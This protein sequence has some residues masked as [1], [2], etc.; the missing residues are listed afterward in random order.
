M[1]DSPAPSPSSPR[2]IT[3]PNILFAII[4]FAG[5]F[6]RVWEF[7]ALPAGLNQ[8]EASIGLDAYDLLHY[9]VDRNNVSFPVNF[10]SWDSGMDA[11]YGYI[12]IPFVGFGLTAFTIRLP[13]LLSGILS[14][15]LIYFVGKRTL[16]VYFGLI[17]MF[18]LAISPWHIMMSR[19]GLNDNILPFVFLA[20]FAA[21]VNSTLENKW[22]LVASFFF[23][24]CLYAYGAA[25]VAVPLFLL[26]AIPIL[27]IHKSVS[28]RTAIQ[29]VCIFVLLSAPIG[30]FLLVNSLHLQS[31]AIG[32]Y[33]IPRL[34]TQARYE[35][36]AAIFS[37]DPLSI[38]KNN[39]IAAIQ[40][41]MGKSDGLPWNELTNYQYFYARA[42]ILSFVGAVLLIPSWGMRSQKEKWLMLSW[43]A[44]A[45]CIGLMQPVNVNRFNLI[46]IPLIF[47]AAVCVFC[48][49]A[50][51][52]P[53]S[54]ILLVP[55][56]A[57]FILFNRDYHGIEYRQSIGKE[58]F[59]GLL[60]ALE[61]TRSM[62][63]HPVCVTGSVN[64]PYIYVLFLEKKNPADYIDHLIYNQPDSSFRTVLFYGR[65]SFGDPLC[66]R[67]PDAV[68]ILSSG[69]S[70]DT[71]SAYESKTFGNFIVYYPKQP[72]DP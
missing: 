11:L 51:A 71:A 45:F 18:F 66:L 50:Y 22:F 34:P 15:P 43:L 65:Y 16:G 53:F 28:L 26:C 72:G 7:A 62:D 2:W 9:G 14:L 46:F 6:A 70:M 5:I 23:G 48:L 37:A 4:L 32:P 64:Q 30:L 49:L 13:L 60:P 42:Y 27:L 67:Q 59:D 1:N 40:L 41:I 52:R 47:C 68:S 44:A 12:L 8:D 54:L 24:L 31:I 17:V 20:G 29:G 69:E 58:F 36:M 35:F 38:F 55:F 56:V 61:F 25:Y 33:T 3:L 19:W 21:T 10:T 57:A 39:M 63:N